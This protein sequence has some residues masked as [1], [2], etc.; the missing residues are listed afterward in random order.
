MV[1]DQKLELTGTF[2]LHFVCLRTG[3]ALAFGNLI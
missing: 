3:V 2:Y 1:G